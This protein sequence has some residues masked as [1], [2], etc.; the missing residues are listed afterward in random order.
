[1]NRFETLKALQLQSRKD[2]DEIKTSLYSYFI[3]QLERKTKNPTDDE[4]IAEYKAYIKQVSAIAYTKAEDIAKRDLEVTLTTDLLPK[5]LTESEIVD[6]V[7]S[8]N[9][10]DMG[11]LMKH[12]KENYNGSFNGGLVKKVFE[13]V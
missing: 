13:N 11:S 7:K 1:M 3:S 9:S 8:L 2:R 6:I 12:F 4:V 5:Q 10:S